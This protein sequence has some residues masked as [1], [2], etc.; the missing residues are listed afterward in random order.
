MLYHLWYFLDTGNRY[1]P[2]VC[3]DCRDIL[4]M[5]YEPKDVAI[6]NIKGV[7][8]RCIIWNMSKSNAINRLNNSK[9]DIKGSI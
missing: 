3:I 9:L 8:Y 6:L 1:E 7:D 5:V 4:T 2:E